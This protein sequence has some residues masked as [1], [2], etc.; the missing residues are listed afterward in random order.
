MPE[1]T[2]YSD[3]NLAVLRRI[4]PGS[5]VLDIGCGTG[6]MGGIIRKEK[7]CTVYGVDADPAVLKLAAKRLDKV[8]VGD[9]EDGNF[10]FPTKDFNVLLLCSVLEHLRDPHEVL[11]RLVKQLPKN[12]IVII[13]VPNIALW[14]MRLKLL[15]G[16]FNYTPSGLLD[17]THLKFFTYKTA[18]KW[19]E[20]SG[21]RI[22]KTD[23]N[24]FFVRAFLPLIRRMYGSPDGTSRNFSNEKVLKSRPYAFYRKVVAPLEALVARIRKQLFAIEFVFVAE[25][26]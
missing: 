24:P 16:Q 25:K 3:L 21:L 5:T 15:F 11:P 19:V 14:E 20:G 1:V 13:C 23:I 8:F 26:K 10:T 6:F 2:D 18:K 7:H 4:P 9:I 12:A 22:L 17:R